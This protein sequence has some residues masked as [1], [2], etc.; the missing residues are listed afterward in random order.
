M[1]ELA[2]NHA[3]M[4][5]TIAKNATLY[6]KGSEGKMFPVLTMDPQISNQYKE[7]ST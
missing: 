4:A 3:E 7:V 2:N 6:A 1:E 5:E